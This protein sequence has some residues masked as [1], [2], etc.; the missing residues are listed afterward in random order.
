[1]LY[2]AFD[3]VNKTL[4][5]YNGSAVALP[6][7]YQTNLVELQLQFVT[8]TPGSVVP[9][10]AVDVSGAATF[11]RLTIASKVT[12]T[13]GDEATYALAQAVEGAFT[14]D[15]INLW[16]TGVI[17][18][19]TAAMSTYIGAQSSQPGVIE[20]DLTTGGVD[21]NTIFQGT[22]TV[23]GNADGGGAPSVT[24]VNGTGGTT[25]L[26]NGVGGVTIA[27]RLVTVAGLVWGA[28]PTA[29]LIHIHIPADGN[30]VIF[31]SYILGSAT[32]AGFQFNLSGA[33]DNNNYMFTY[34]PV[35]N[36]PD[37]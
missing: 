30:G 20:V 21:P 33:P 19:D 2:L 14:W 22:C 8:P 28:V 11:P 35:F 27:G 26:Q 24:P 29:V 25:L 6:G 5:P 31:G 13:L 36:A 3:I 15:P 16:Y 17:N 7:F 37:F 23:F 32:A 10:S 1:M 12:G 18:L 34:I 4:V 9:Y